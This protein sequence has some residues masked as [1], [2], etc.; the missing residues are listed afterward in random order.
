MTEKKSLKV[1]NDKVDVIRLV[2]DILKA[3][4]DVLRELA[5]K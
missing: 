4:K 2:K 1:D 5:D 3:K